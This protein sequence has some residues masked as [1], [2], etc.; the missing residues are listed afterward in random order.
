MS[1]RVRAQRRD[2]IARKH[3]A[4]QPVAEQ[5]QDDDEQLMDDWQE[6]PADEDTRTV[7][8]PLDC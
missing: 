5:D 6:P 1:G 3:I 2:A 8:G 4:L 7:I